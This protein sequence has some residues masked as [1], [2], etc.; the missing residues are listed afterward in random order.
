MRTKVAMFAVRK[1]FAAAI[2]YNF[3][4]KVEQKNRRTLRHKFALVSFLIKCTPENIS[5]FYERFEKEPP[6]H[7]S[8]KTFAQ[9]RIIYSCNKKGEIK[10]R[11]NNITH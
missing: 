2:C 10:S 8:Q 3:P 4:L 7:F 6:I 9:Q 11:K 1:I 5:S